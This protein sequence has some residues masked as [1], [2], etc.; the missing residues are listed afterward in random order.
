MDIV[1]EHDMIIFAVLARKHDIAATDFPGEK[2]H[3]LVLHGFSVERNHFKFDKILCFNQLRQN[4]KTVIGGIGSI[5]GDFLVVIEKLNK[6]GI[7]NASAFI[8]RNGK[9]HPFGYAVIGVKT[10]LVIGI[11]KPAHDLKGSVLNRFE[12]LRFFAKHSYFFQ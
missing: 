11:R 3:A 4:C 5:I 8:F 7:F 10:H 6:T 9:D 12:E 2:R 1:R